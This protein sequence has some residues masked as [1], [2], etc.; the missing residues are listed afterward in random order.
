VASGVRL[1]SPNFFHEDLEYLARVGRTT[2][3]L[4]FRMLATQLHRDATLNHGLLRKGLHLRIS[5]SRLIRVYEE[6]SRR[7]RESFL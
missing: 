6:V 5:G 1:L 4:E 2:D 7:R 3:W